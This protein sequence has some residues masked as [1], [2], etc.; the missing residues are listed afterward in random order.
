MKKKLYPCLLILGLLSFIHSKAESYSCTTKFETRYG[1]IILPVEIEGKIYDFL[2]DTGAPTSISKELQSSYQFKVVKKKKQIDSDGASRKIAYVKI[3]SFSLA[4][5]NFNNHQASVHNYNENP[6]IK[7]L[8]IDGIIGSNSMH[9][10]TWTIDYQHNS[11]TISEDQL[12]Y[13]ANTDYRYHTDGQK[14]LLLNLKT[15]NATIKNVKVDYGSV[16]GLSVPNKIFKVLND[17]K[18]FSKVI[19]TKG[20]KMSG[21]FGRKQKMTIYAG[22]MPESSIGKVQLDSFIIKTGSKGLLGMQVLQDYLVTIDGKNRILRLEQYAQRTKDAFKTFGIGLGIEDGKI[23]VLNILDGSEAEKFGLSPGMEIKSWGPFAFDNN[24][25]LC[26]YMLSE[27][28]MLKEV[29][30]I[31]IAE[32]GVER[33]LKIRA[34]NYYK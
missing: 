18:E 29:E 1:L 10:S 31:Y 9:L 25:T 24:S 5:L 15:Q 17:R 33:S 6:A 7:C 26:N 19:K 32:K 30:L 22:I 13:N 21:L 4:G 12:D 23:I 20:Y 27:K 14:S 16:G 3:P 11:M 34:R 28:E 8:K 2:F